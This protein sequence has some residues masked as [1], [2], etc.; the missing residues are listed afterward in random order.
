MSALGCFLLALLI[1]T[2]HHTLHV[3]PFGF[4]YPFLSLSSVCTGAACLEVLGYPFHLGSWAQ[5]GWGSASLT[6]RALRSGFWAPESCLRGMGSC[7]GGTQLLH[8]SS[9]LSIGYIVHLLNNQLLG[10][11]TVLGAWV[12][13]EQT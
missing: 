9:N 12:M 5:P 6:L 7:G 11:E 2:S 4:K 8:T 1:Q 13:G 3:I 10:T